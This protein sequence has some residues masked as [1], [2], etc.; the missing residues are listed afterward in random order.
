MNL[1]RLLW[2][3]LVLA[4]WPALVQA[5]D[6]AFPN[7]PLRILVPFTAG[8]ATD[9]IARIVMPALTEKWGRQAVIDNRSGASGTIG[10]AQRYQ[11]GQISA[12]DV[13][14]GDPALQ[15]FLQTETF[16]TLIHDKQAL[17]ALASPSVQAALMAPG[18][19][20]ALAAPLNSSEMSCAGRTWPEI[21]KRLLTATA[22][23]LWWIGI[24]LK[25]AS[26]RHET[27]APVSYNPLV[28]TEP[29]TF[30]PK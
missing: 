26:L 19:A 3:V 27:S 20:Q 1:T 17:A 22:G 9:V 23:G 2:L 14:V 8:S 5:A 4:V 7:R 29:C 12:S 10:A 21:G 16:D 6:P 25:I 28:S 30:I 13:K 15:A 18:V 11:S 24:C